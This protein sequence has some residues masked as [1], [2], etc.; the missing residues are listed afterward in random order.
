MTTVVDHNYGTSTTG[1]PPLLA[2]P[3]Y[4]VVNIS[5]K[6]ANGDIIGETRANANGEWNRS[7]QLADGNYTV[8]FRG[9]FKP[10]GLGPATIYHQTTT[11][12]TVPITVPLESA[13]ESIGEIGATGPGGPQ[14]PRG[15]Q[16]PAGGSGPQGEK[17][18]IGPTGPQGIQGLQGS[19]GERGEKGTA[20]TQGPA[21]P[22]GAQGI[23]GAV[24]PAGPQGPEGPSGPAGTV[25]GNACDI[26]IG[27]PSDGYWSDGYFL[28]TDSTKVCDALDDLNEVIRVLAPDTPLSLQGIPLDM[29]GEPL[30]DGYASDKLYQNYKLAAGE[31]IDA[32]Y[33]GGKIVLDD[34]FILVNRTVDDPESGGDDTFFPGDE[35]T[36]YSIITADQLEQEQGAIDL[37]TATIG[38]SN[39]SLTINAKNDGYNGFPGWVRGGGVINVNGRLGTG[40][41]KIVMRHNPGTGNED[42]EEYEIF[43]DTSSTVQGMTGTMIIT[44][45]SPVYREFSGIRSYTLAATFTL[46]FTGQHNFKDT[47]VDDAFSWT[48]DLWSSISTASTTI[49]LHDPAWDGTISDIPHVDDIP[50]LGTYNDYSFTI[51]NANVRELNARMTLVFSKPGRTDTTEQESNSY[52]LVDTYSDSS[53]VLDEPFDDENYRL[54]DNDGSAYP[55]N[56]DVSPVSVTGNFTSTDDL[57]DGHAVVFHGSLYHPTKPGSFAGDFSLHLPIG[58]DY[59]GF[60]SDA[61]YLR[62]FVDSGNAHSNGTIQLEGLTI[63]DIAPLGTGNVN[64]EI[65]LPTETGWLDMGSSFDEHDFVG[66]DGD[67]CRTSQSSD[68]WSFT[69]GTFSTVDSDYMIIVRVTIRNS[70]SV[71]TRMRITSW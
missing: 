6:N 31:D 41:N 30:Y 5:I 1:F 64:V 19:Q 35:G 65:K 48:N 57:T 62:A 49:N 8:E 15:E 13:T 16:G 29:T 24:G 10:I 23:Q 22:Q 12:I 11:S 34:T 59:S 55:D 21:G 45:L 20:G 68:T 50:V 18:P 17:G 44:E 38:T 58:P 67:G 53:T 36:L 71:I 69:F 14:G 27:I 25:I 51:D 7:F 54:P 3:I 70:D 4:G 46:E 52:R 56:Y 60:T 37:V 61:V 2:I 43:Y 66:A 42:S 28:W 40:Y 32:T 33:T 9:R 26:D 39:G 63:A 47:Y